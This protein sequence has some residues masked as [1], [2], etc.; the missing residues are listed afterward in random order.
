MGQVCRDSSGMD[1]STPCDVVEAGGGR[2]ETRLINCRARWIDSSCRWRRFDT[3]MV[4]KQ[5]RIV[6]EM[7]VKRVCQY[8]CQ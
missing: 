1:C 4:G 2:R 7:G 6:A 8:V 3:H 5:A